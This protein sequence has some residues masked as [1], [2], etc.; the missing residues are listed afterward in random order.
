MA[1]GSRGESLFMQGYTPEEVSNDKIP[2]SW[3]PFRVQCSSTDLEIERRKINEQ[4]AL[5]IAMSVPQRQLFAGR[6][7]GGPGNNSPGH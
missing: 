1:L 6:L 7:R 3:Q 2:D 4:E 5:H